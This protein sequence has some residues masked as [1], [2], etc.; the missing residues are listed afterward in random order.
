MLFDSSLVYLFAFCYVQALLVS[1][2][3]LLVSFVFVSG[4]L[5]IKNKA[6]MCHVKTH[7]TGCLALSKDLL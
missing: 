6:N 7:Q 1:K 5:R 2:C 3:N 4:R